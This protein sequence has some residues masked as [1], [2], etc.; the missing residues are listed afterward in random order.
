MNGREGQAA[1]RMLLDQ[2]GP[3]SR[4]GFD[5]F[6]SDSVSLPRFPRMP[7]GILGNPPEM[8]TGISIPSLDHGCHHGKG[9]QF[10]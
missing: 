1:Q 8:A 7:S 9:F 4:M 10:R 5:H 3:Y 2:D 6:I